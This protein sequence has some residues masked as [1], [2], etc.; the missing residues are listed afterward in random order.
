MVHQVDHQGRHLTDTRSR[1]RSTNQGG[2]T[3]RVAPVS[4]ALDLEAGA[5]TRDCDFDWGMGAERIAEWERELMG[6]NDE[7]DAYQ[8]ALV[9][10]VDYNG[11]VDGMD[12]RE[13]V[14]LE[15]ADERDDEDAYFARFDGD[16]W[17]PAMTF[18]QVCE[19][20]P[21]GFHVITPR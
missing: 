12:V 10:Q 5:N 16:I 13:D 1:L 15:H 17:P 8:G 18:T 4:T 6:L 14:V 19:E 21:Y 7:D 9:H 20:M 2:S 11:D 3:T